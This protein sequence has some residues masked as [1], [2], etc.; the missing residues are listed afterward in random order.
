MRGWE[1]VYTHQPLRLVEKPDPVAKP[2]YVVIDVKASGLCHSDVGALEDEKWLPLIKNY[3][4]IIGHEF[5]GVISEIG[6]GVTGYKIG[7]KVGVCPMFASD[8][9]GPGYGR[10]GGYATKSTAPAEMLVP[11]PEGVTF[12]QAAAATDA[13]MTSYHAVVVQGGIKPG[14][15]VGI[16][17][18]GGLGQIGTRIAVL[19]GCDVYAASRNPAAR[20]L[21]M[22]LGCKAAY[23][24]IGEAAHHEL[25]VIIDFAG[26][27]KTT[28]DSLE[29]IGYKGRVV[30]VGMAQLEATINTMTLILKQA[31]VVGSNGGTTQDIADVYELMASGDLKPD[32]TEIGFE[33]IGEGLDRLKKGGVKGRLVAIIDK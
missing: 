2:G 11:V 15:K 8:G 22:E 25:D 10:D 3:P 13:G 17:G 5:A 33:E 31:E 20:E 23:P 32:I 4:C 14:M 12:A 1:F 6:E 18:V 7:D 24:T 26:A 30:V 28:A 16:V 29:A 19:K 9:T 21:A 27:G